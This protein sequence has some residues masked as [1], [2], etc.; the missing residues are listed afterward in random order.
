MPDFMTLTLAFAA[1]VVGMGWL[2]LTIDMNYARVGK[3]GTL[4]SSGLA[5][6]RLLGAIGVTASLAL[7]LSVD[8]ASMAALVWIML[9]AA[10]AL[11]ITFTL[12]WRAH[13]LAVLAPRSR[14]AH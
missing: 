7:C 11:V 1:A 9:L 4:T 10:A 14:R 2:A 8:H 6:L 13:W 5:R 3:R 12:A